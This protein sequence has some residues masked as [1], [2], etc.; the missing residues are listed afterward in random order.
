MTIVRDMDSDLY[1]LKSLCIAFT[2][3]EEDLVN[4]HRQQV[5]ETMNIVKEVSN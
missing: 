2:Q 3:E 4:A 5:E 1:V